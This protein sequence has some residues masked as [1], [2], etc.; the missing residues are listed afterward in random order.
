MGYY[1]ET[2]SNR[3][4]ADYLLKNYNAVEIDRPIYF[5]EIPEDMA[6]L[7]VVDNGMFEAAAFAYDE[8]EF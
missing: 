6:L 8:N 3:N 4:K 2:D 1:I 7:V 5:Q